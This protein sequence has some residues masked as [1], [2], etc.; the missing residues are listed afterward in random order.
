MAKDEEQIIILKRF[1]EQLGIITSYRNAWKEQVEASVETLMSLIRMLG[2][3]VNAIHEVLPVFEQYQQNLSQQPLEP[4]YVVWDQKQSVIKFRLLPEEAAAVS[5]SLITEQGSIIEEAVNIRRRQKI[6]VDSCQIDIQLP[7][8]PLGYH[9]FTLKTGKRQYQSLIISAPGTIYFDDRLCDEKKIG[10]F[11]PLYSL[12][13]D[14]SIGCGDLGDMDS[15]SQW[16]AEERLGLIASTPLFSAFHNSPCEPSPYSP[17]SRLFANEF[18]LDL[19]Q[20]GPIDPEFIAAIEALNQLPFIDYQRAASLKRE[21]ASEQFRRILEL[22]ENREA[23]NR[24]IEAH[25]EIKVYAL[26][27]AYMECTGEEWRN[28]PQRQRDGLLT[29]EDVPSDRYHY[30]L[31]AQWQLHQQLRVLKKKINQRGQYLYLDLPI[32]AHRNGFDVWRQQTLYLTETAMGSPP[33]PLFLEGQNWGMPALNPAKLRE[34]AYLWFIQLIQNIFKQVDILRIDHVMGFNRLYLIP[35]GHPASDGAY[36]R[37][38]AE[39]IYAILCLESHRHQVMIVGENLGSVPPETNRLMKHHGM[40]NM[41]VLQYALDAREKIIP[42]T[43][44]TLTCINTHDMPPFSAWCQGL[45]ITKF[46]ELKLIDET[47]ARQMH[48]K[49]RYQL[50][51]LTA[52]LK[53]QQ[54]NSADLLSS[55]WQMLAQSPAALQLVNIEDLWGEIYSQNIP[56]ATEEPNWQRKLRYSMEQIKQMSTI[57]RQLKEIHKRRRPVEHPRQSLFSA[58]D[59]HLFNEGTHFHL[60]R[61][62]GAHVIKQ[63]NVTGV[64]FAVWAPNASQVSV[65]GSFN[66]WNKTEHSLSSRGNS[67]IWE[68]FIPGVKVGDLYKYTIESDRLQFTAQKADPFAFY[69]ETPPCTASIVWDLHYE[70]QDEEWLKNRKSKQS[71]NSPISIYEVHLG[72]WRRVPEENNRYL[73]YRELAPLLAD[74]VKQMGFTHVEFLPVMEH[75]FYGSW[76]YQTVSYFAPSARFGTPQD[77]MYLIDY[78]HQQDIAV[79]LDWVP[80]HFPMDEHGLAQFDGTHLFEHSDERK[81]FHPDWKS[82]IF[83]YGRH[84]VQAFLISSAMFWFEKYHIDAIRVDAV[85][86]MLYLNYSRKEGEWLPNEKGG[87][88]NLEAIH[89]LR[90]L[91]KTAYQYFPDIQMFAEESTAWTGVSAPIEFGGLGFGFKWDMGWMHDTLLYFSRDP[92]FRRYHQHE[93]SFRMVYAFTEN[94]TLSLS[95][96]EVVYGKGSLINKM[97]GDE[98]CKFANLRLLYGYMFCL[99]GKK[100][101]FMGSEFGQYSE[102][103]HESS[104][105]WHVL[106]YPI[107]QGLQHWVRDLNRLYR[108]QTALHELDWQA[109]GFEWIDCSD[110]DNSVY[111]FIRKSSQNECLLIAFNCTPVTRSNYRLGVPEAGNWQLLLD[112]DA[113]LYGG[114]AQNQNELLTAEACPFHNR[115]YSLSLTLPGLSLVIYQW[116]K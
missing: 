8:L 86:S 77:F 61:H 83:N 27:R 66:H 39:E 14:K 82:A 3:P 97:P 57:S 70:W 60:Y 45:D 25:P 7:A 76:G 100:L 16:M 93:L 92:I 62:L 19:R 52:T 99:P 80:S 44:K 20:C 35:E 84:E 4:V 72:S 85:A 15:L 109:H 46:Q 59:L 71:L 22:P 107:H 105:D 55:T 87:H 50:K 49:R 94:F 28:W 53:K 18:Y 88:E 68:G 9:Q 38:P 54:L 108:S 33:D 104:L 13:S 69:Q 17:V 30:H 65:V 96:D 43:C 10:L 91:N 116:I 64:N 110:A 74:Y 1:V 75:P 106:D 37:Y 48:K 113:A 78:L 29:E 98:Y 21:I 114:S 24:F 26:F 111:S 95:H 81:G 11:C 51:T 67:G 103:N 31:A 79:I 12:H 2:Y 89:F 115:P 36:L 34:Q 90:T 56:N 58:Q 23:L 5:W 102:W 40:L 73:S 6:S 47:Y 41:N 112:S 42:T 101:I 63:D 32:G